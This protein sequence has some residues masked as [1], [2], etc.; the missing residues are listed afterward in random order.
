[1]QTL[2]KVLFAVSFFALSSASFAV[3]SISG[4]SGTYSNGSSV[5]IT[6]SGFGSGPNVVIFDD[7]EGGTAGAN[8][9]TGAGS[10]TVGQWAARSGCATYSTATAVS[11]T[12]A[13]RADM[14][15]GWLNY[16]E[17]SL[18]ANTTQIFY[19]WYKYI[20]TGQ[21]WP[22]EGTTDGVNWKQI[23]T[24]RNDSGDNDI[25]TP[26]LQDG[27]SNW[28]WFGNNA[29]NYGTGKRWMSNSTDVQHFK[30]QWHRSWTYME[31]DPGASTT[32][33]FWRYWVLRSDGV[34]QAG[35][36]DS[37]NL[38]QSGGWW[39]RTRLNGYGRGTSNSYPMFDDFYLATGPNAR[40]RV[41]IGNA[42]TYA[43]STKLTIA[44]PTSWS[45]SSITATFRRG[46]LATGTHYLYVFDSAG[47]VNETGYPIT[48]S[49]DAGPT[50]YTAT[51]SAG[52]NGS[53]S[54]A[55]RVVDAGQST[56]FTI[57]PNSGYTGTVSG[58]CGGSPA[59][60][61]GEFV[62]TTNAVNANCSVSVTF[63]GDT[64]PPVIS[65]VLPSGEQPYGTTSVILSVETSENAT[66][67]YSST[68]ASYASM[69]NTFTTT[70]ELLHEQTL[71]TTNGSSYIRYIRCS[72]AAG[73]ANT[74]SS[75]ASYSVSA[76]DFVV[77]DNAGSGV[78]QSGDWS[79]S[80]YFPGYYGV[81]YHYSPNATGH[82]FQW[83]TALTASTYDVY[84]WWPAAA[85]R[86]TDATY[87]ITHSGGT[88]T[89]PA[90]QTANGSQWNLL[91]TYTFGTTGTVRLLSGAT[92]TEG[93]AADAIRFVA[94]SFDETPPVL[95][96]ISPA[97]DLT[98]IVSSI[99]LQVT[100]NELSTCN[101]GG[102]GVAYSAMNPF[103]ITGGTSHSSSIDVVPG[104]VYQRCFICRDSYANESAE[105]CT[106]FS[107][108]ALP[109]R[110]VLH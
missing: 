80:T 37:A 21:N 34:S 64:T 38:L 44:T 27:G 25:V 74:A 7:F 5:T 76:V 65:N 73:N 95:S 88:A 48:V 52:S 54:P 66:C 78:T 108:P 9:A 94:S 100:T 45:A 56:S 109:K 101:Y 20:A 83:T 23:W 33:G 98:E 43:A 36:G 77:L 59:T 84:A 10:A 93:A 50:T 8:I 22:G 92:G 75:V 79:T 107:V 6:G 46:N 15:C 55:S 2:I 57:T 28:V 90:N 72:D 12:K 99:I 87:E 17:V 61:P 16:A 32:N 3:P 41:E 24:M 19:S 51:C 49:G 58:T 29:R 4:S 13:F 69:A 39:S 96:E 67:R 97:G 47:T 53:C 105:S 91:G 11:G 30:G 106:R 86:P 62:Y 71:A 42:N 81:N 102:K 82:W 103:S 40:A 14:S 85:G 1:M 18:P 63:A 60:S 89:V 26:V 31:G 35:Y 110:R 68:D 104:G 70:G